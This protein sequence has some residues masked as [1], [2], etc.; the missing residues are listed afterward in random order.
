MAGSFPTNYKDQAKYVRH[1]TSGKHKKPKKNGTTASHANNVKSVKSANTY[2]NKGKAKGV[3]YT[4]IGMQ[5]TESAAHNNVM[6]SKGKPV[7]KNGGREVPENYRQL[8]A[9]EMQRMLLGNTVENIQGY[10]AHSG[11]GEGYKSWAGGNGED[12]NGPRN[13]AHA[14]GAE[15]DGSGINTDALANPMIAYNPVLT[16]FA[17]MYSDKAR[18]QTLGG[19]KSAWGG[20]KGAGK[21][22][23]GKANDAWNYEV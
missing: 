16:P 3:R 5:N 18:N 21:W 8:I 6:I 2:S 13:L 20:V 9:E 1:Y 19:A 7:G 17:H 12:R 23:G 15:W 10:G 4:P 14:F 22:L 11:G